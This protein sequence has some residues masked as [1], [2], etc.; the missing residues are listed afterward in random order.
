MR[1]PKS[2]WGALEHS[3]QKRG[4]LQG[5]HKGR[6]GFDVVGGKR[7]RFLVRHFFGVIAFGEQIGDLIGGEGG[8]RQLGAYLALAFGAV[9]GGALGFEGGSSIFG[10]SGQGDRGGQCNNQK[11][12][13][14]F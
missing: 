10:E 6:D 5:F 2:T 14:R 1:S 7:Y 9:T 13:E 8:S 4:L 11:Q 3:C 12:D